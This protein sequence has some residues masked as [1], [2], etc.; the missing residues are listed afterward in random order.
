MDSA[1][2]CRDQSAECLRMMRLTQSAAESTMLRNLSS[3]WSKIANQTDRYTD[4]ID[5]KDRAA[6][7]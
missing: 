7:K 1:Q 2:R 6:R 4:L 3:S 5:E